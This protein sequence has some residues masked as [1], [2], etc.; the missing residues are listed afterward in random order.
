MFHFLNRVVKKVQVIFAEIATLN[1]LQQYKDIALDFLDLLY[2]RRVL[3]EARVQNQPEFK[4]LYKEQRWM[5]IQRN[6]ND[7]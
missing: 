3:T 5:N 6:L 2:L 1:N 4:I 7:Q